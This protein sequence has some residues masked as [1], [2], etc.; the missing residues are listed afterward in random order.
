MLSE[1][2]YIGKALAPAADRYNTNPATD[3]FHLA[4][5]AEI[6]FLVYQQ[7]GTTGKAT[8]TVEE[9][10]DVSASNS[11]AI[12]FK[13]RKLPTGAITSATTAGF[14][15]TPNSEDIYEIYV[16]ASD[17]SAGYGYVRAVLT[18][19]ANDPVNAAVIAI[20]GER[21]YAGVTQPSPLT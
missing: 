8:I 4:E 17:L 15:T 20:L 10:D 6:T 5:S 1:R 9:C 16:K 13:Y 7:G 12:A 3:I 19:A 11:A 18:E 21:R 2:N 14:D